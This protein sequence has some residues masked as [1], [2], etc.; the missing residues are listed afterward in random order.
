MNLSKTQDPFRFLKRKKN[1]TPQKLKDNSLEEH[2][3]ILPDNLSSLA[4]SK[5]SK[6]EETNSKG[7]HYDPNKYYSS[8]C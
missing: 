8:K 2:Y 7:N 3:K 5:I 6:I 4:E 1:V